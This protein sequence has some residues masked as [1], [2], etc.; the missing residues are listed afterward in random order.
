V[1]LCVSVSCAVTTALTSVYD[2]LKT[3]I[4]DAILC[5]IDF[6]SVAK[7]DTSSL[8]DLLLTVTTANAH[9]RKKYTSD[10]S[11]SQGSVATRLKC[12]GGI[13]NNRFVANFLKML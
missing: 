11:V 10:S 3:V 4:R 13:S 7:I 6:G 1:S 2:N 5:L 9:G 8:L 12:G